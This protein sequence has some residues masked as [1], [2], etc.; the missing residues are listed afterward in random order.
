MIFLD[1]CT[2]TKIDEEV[3]KAMEPYLTK[4]YGVSAGLYNSAQE[5]DE[6][7]ERAQELIANGLKTKPEE[8]VFTDSG[9]EANN[10]AIKGIAYAN[11]GK[12]L[13]IS[14]IEHPS[15]TAC[16][17]ELEKKGFEVDYVDVD[18]KG[19]VHPEQIE[20]IVREDTILVSIIYVS[21]EIGT[22]EPIREIVEVVKE[23]N[24]QTYFHTDAAMAFGKI[25]IET[26]GVDLITLSS[27]KIH[28]PKGA[29]ALFVREG[30]KIK[31]ITHGLISKFEL[32]PG[33][34]NVPAIVGF[35]KAAE[36]AIRDL[37]KN[38]KKV[39]K[40]QN[41]LVKGIE[42]KIP[43]VILN[44]P[45]EKR[46]P[47]NLNFSF[48]YIEGE[49]IVLRLNEKGIEAATESRCAERE[50]KPNPTLIAIGVPPEVAHGAIRFTLSKYNT[51]EEMDYL[52]GVLPKI[53][54]ELREISPFG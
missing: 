44:G 46:S 53:V 8:I 24:P 40:L 7:I 16:A 26:E 48:K 30:T 11:K 38:A 34:E 18:P 4:K 6:A 17:L 33:A 13:I 32:K 5:A 42:S 41:F 49:S 47:Y 50:L 10:L 27:H 45:R 19:F 37:E 51:K 9:T 52:L 28:G 25:P 12:H 36:I 21:H 14:K 35:G 1:N 31:P 29:G 20:R 15:V 43:N 22:I 23:K 3:L 39:K 54:E 2:T